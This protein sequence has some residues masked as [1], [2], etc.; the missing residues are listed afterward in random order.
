MC[1]PAVF[2]GVA[3]L[4]LDEGDGVEL[5]AAEE[6]LDLVELIDQEEDFLAVELE[7]EVSHAEVHCL[8]PLQDAVVLYQGNALTVQPE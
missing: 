8:P 1:D 3:E 2:V 6:L 4:L 5:V 7:F